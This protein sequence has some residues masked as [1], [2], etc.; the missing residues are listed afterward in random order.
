MAGAV[1]LSIVCGRALV[2]QYIPTSRYTSLVCRQETFKTLWN[3][4]TIDHVRDSAIEHPAKSSMRT[5]KLHF[6]F[7]SAHSNVAQVE[8]APDYA[9]DLYSAFN[10]SKENHILAAR[11]TSTRAVILGYS[12]LAL[13]LIH[14]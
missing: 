3:K 11:E 10:F 14:I 4:L 6:S 8:S 7:E 13:S 2:R 9:D 5:E 1:F 12:R